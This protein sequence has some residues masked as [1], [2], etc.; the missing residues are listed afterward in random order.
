MWSIHGHTTWRFHGKTENNQYSKESGETFTEYDQDSLEH[1]GWAERAPS[2]EHDS[3]V[4]QAVSAR[5][6][7]ALFSTNQHRFD[8]KLTRR[9]E[10]VFHKVS[11]RFYYCPCLQVDDERAPNFMLFVEIFKRPRVFFCYYARLLL[12]GAQRD[13]GRFRS[14]RIYPDISHRSWNRQNRY[15]IITG[16]FKEK[17]FGNNSVSVLPELEGFYNAQNFA[18]RM[19]LFVYSKLKD[20]HLVK[21]NDCTWSIQALYKTE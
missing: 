12:I 9:T 6:K 20:F 17:N 8:A 7:S 16:I 14:I 4:E 3:A 2:F 21:L 11:A 10:Q 5:K 15:Q 19:L 13:G 1:F 18:K